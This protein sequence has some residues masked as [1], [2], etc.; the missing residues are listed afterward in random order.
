[1]VESGP[2]PDSE[3]WNRIPETCRASLQK[4][5][6]RLTFEAGETVFLQGDSFRGPYVIDKGIFKVYQ[7]NEA[8]KEAILNFFFPGSIIAA[9]P[10]L[11]IMPVY[12]ASCEAVRDGAVIYLPVDDCVSLMQEAPE[13]KQCFQEDFVSNAEFFKNKTTLLMLHTTEERVLFFLEALGA[14]EREVYLNIPKNQIALYLGVSAEAFSRAFT[15]LK[16]QGRVTE[17]DGYVR[18]IAESDS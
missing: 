8:G 5:A 1:M 15:A 4:V 13:L 16:K 10:M 12:P 14:D 9:L 7:L 6:R 17:S 2:V 11:K 18:L 3:F